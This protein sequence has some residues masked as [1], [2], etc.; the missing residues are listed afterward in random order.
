MCDQ[1][2]RHLQGGGSGRDEWEKN[3]EKS[4]TIKQ[5][6]DKTNAEVSLRNA[7]RLVIGGW[8]FDGG[9]IEEIPAILKDMADDYDRLIQKEANE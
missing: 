2:R 4:Q 3:M 8:L 7:I 9:D 1:L 5:A 6:F